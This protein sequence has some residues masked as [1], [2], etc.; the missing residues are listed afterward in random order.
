[1]ATPHP[2]ILLIRSEAARVLAI[3]ERALFNLT[4]NGK[5]LAVRIGRSVRYRPEDLA[6]FAKAHA[7]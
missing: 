4:S 1:M 6:A 7:S 3:S 2:P 5:L